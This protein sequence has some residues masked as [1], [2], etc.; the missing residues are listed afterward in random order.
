MATDEETS[1]SPGWGPIASTKTGFVVVMVFVSIFAVSMRLIEANASYAATVQSIAADAKASVAMDAWLSLSVVVALITTVAAWMLRRG[2][3]GVRALL[4]VAAFALLLAALATEIY[5][6]HWIRI[7]EID[8][9]ADRIQIGEFVDDGTSAEDTIRRKH[10]RA[11]A[12]L[13]EAESLLQKVRELKA[14]LDADASK[15]IP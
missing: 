7:P 3:F 11:A 10:E 6:A 12:A 13:R 5:I 4:L 9:V 14:S 8:R 15:K 1:S 2:S